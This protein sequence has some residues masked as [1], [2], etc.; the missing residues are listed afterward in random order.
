MTENSVEIGGLEFI[1]L[2]FLFFC[3]FFWAG[4]VAQDGHVVLYCRL[5]GRSDVRT[6]NRKWG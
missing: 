4:R 1:S 6:G 2:F 5:F 3:F